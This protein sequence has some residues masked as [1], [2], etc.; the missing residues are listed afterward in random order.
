ML[1]CGSIGPGIL[2]NRGV[3]SWYSHEQHDEQ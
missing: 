3:C 2:R 1:A